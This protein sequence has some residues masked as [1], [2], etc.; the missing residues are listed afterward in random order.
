MP[1]VNQTI[2]QGLASQLASLSQAAADFK[3]DPKANKANLEAIATKTLAEIDAE[4][5]S[6]NVSSG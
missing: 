3:A 6:L 1:E 4:I 2:S 5:D